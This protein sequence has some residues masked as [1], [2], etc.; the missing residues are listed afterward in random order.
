[1]AAIGNERGDQFHAEKFMPDAWDLF[2]SG[3]A[4]LEGIIGLSRRMALP[5]GATFLWG[6]RHHP[7]SRLGTR[8]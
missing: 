3:S 5:V 8:D 4:S 1:M 2:R 6:H 7:V